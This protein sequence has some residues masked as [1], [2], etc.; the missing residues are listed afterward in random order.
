M[1]N[2]DWEFAIGDLGDPLAD[3]KDWMLPPYAKCLLDAG[4]Y[5]PQLNEETDVTKQTTIQR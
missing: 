2:R 3:I 5:N 1:N 4:M